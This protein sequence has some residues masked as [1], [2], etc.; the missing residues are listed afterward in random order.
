MG[1]AWEWGCVHI[2]SDP[3]ARCWCCPP[4]LQ[5]PTERDRCLPSGLVLLQ[6]AGVAR[7]PARDDHGEGPG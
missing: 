7:T 5:L 2:S 4:S 6:G 1:A 3:H